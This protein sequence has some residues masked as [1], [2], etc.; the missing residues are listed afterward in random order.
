M[1]VGAVGRF[2]R[3]VHNKYFVMFANHQYQYQQAGGGAVSTGGMV[4]NGNAWVQSSA[5][6][7]PQNGRSSTFST[8]S[9]GGKESRWARAPQQQARPAAA[10]PQQGGP[11]DGLKRYVH[12]CLEKCASEEQKKQVQKETE[13]VIAEALQ[14]GTL[15]TKN[16]DAVPLISLPDYS[17]KRDSFSLQQ[18]ISSKKQKVKS[19]TDM[20]YGHTRGG[21]NNGGY[22]GPS[23]SSPHPNP[24]ASSSTSHQQYSSRQQSSSKYQNHYG[25]ADENEDFI[26]V[27]NFG[28]KK[29]SN[30]YVNPNSAKKKKP[31]DDA[32]FQRSSSTMAQRANRFSGPGGN[33]DVRQATAKGIDARYMGKGVIGGSSKKLD[34]TDYEQMKV[35]GTCRKLEKQYLRLTAPPKAELVRPLEILQQHLGNLKKEWKSKSRRDYLWFCAEMKAVRQDLTVQHIQN[36][37]TVQAYEF[38]ARIALQEGDI[39]EFNQAQTQLKILYE[40]LDDAKS[41]EN[42][43]EFVAYRMIYFVVMSLNKGYKGGSSDLLKLMLSLTSSQRNDP[44]IKHSLQLR[45]AVAEMDYHKFFQLTKSCPNLGGM[46]ISRSVPIMR[47][48]ALQRICRAYRPSVAF[49]FALK[50]LGFS[51]QTAKEIEDGCFVL[52]Y[53]SLPR[54]WCASFFVVAGLMVAE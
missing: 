34:E 18:S 3:S 19:N 27:P 37:F 12:R 24:T 38:H 39:N 35:K 36:S 2:I 32:G 9:Y 5:A 25:P 10:K 42:E 54:R 26:K 29:G 44:A 1:A 21:P 45:A 20:Y 50:E 51:A 28:V 49:V 7:Q 43:N 48:L 17:R 22:Y 13:R 33:A 52:G 14:D 30:K 46:L 41:L 16:W 53:M 31:M 6:A 23:S 15:H 11:P 4:W 47:Y 8:A 40:K